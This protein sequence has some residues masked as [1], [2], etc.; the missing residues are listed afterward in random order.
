MTPSTA[1][2]SVI[3]MVD[4]QRQRSANALRCLLEQTLIDEL[5]ILLVDFSQ[6]EPLPGSHHPSVRLFRE[7]RL[8]SSGQLRA[9]YIAKVKA[10]I[11]AFFED[12]VSVGRTW[13]K[14]IIEAHKAEVAGVGGE[15]H[16]GNEG[17]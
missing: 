9:A 16:N 1:S 13:A 5:D 14:T 6:A 11:V 4:Q 12:H 8:Q 17:Q 10:P 7:E 2:L 15:V 3:L